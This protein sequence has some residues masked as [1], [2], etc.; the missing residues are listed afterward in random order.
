MVRSHDPG[1]GRV[2]RVRRD[3]R[4]RTD[5]GL[6]RPDR[7]AR[8]GPARGH[9]DE[10]GRARDRRP[11]RHGAAGRSRPRA[12]PRHPDP[13]QGQHRDQRRDG[14]DRGVACARRQP[15]AARRDD[16]G[17]PPRGGR[18]HPRQGQPD[19]MGELPRSPPE[20]D[21]GNRRPPQRLECPRRLHPQPVRPRR[22]TRAVRAPGPASPRRP[23][24]ASLAIGTET[25][26]SIVCPSARNAVVG[27]KPTVGLVSQAGLIPISH[28]QDTAGPM[29]RTVTDVAIVLNA[30]RSPF[31]EVVGRHLPRDYRAALRP[32]ALRGARI[33]VD[34]RQ[35]S[36][37]A[38]DDGLNRLAERAF[39]TL[40][41]TGRHAHRPDRVGRHGLDRGRRADGH[42]HRVQGRDGRL[43]AAPAGHADCGRSPT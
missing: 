38:A 21:R 5:G 40:I 2:A 7:A 34:R 43:P 16:R 29:G 26:G 19:R 8:P 23:T 9:R 27:L 36:G 14:D 4:G 35:F 24:C 6:S 3:D 13:G 12:A 1:A 10:P 31:G 25:D 22:P 20:G 17:T 33:G 30:L 32:G 11:T 37:D 41:G 15:R 18:R 42:A 28:S 39:E